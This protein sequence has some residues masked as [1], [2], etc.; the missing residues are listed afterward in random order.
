MN[1]T[2]RFPEH[3]DPRRRFGYSSGRVTNKGNYLKTNKLE[4]ARQVLPITL[5]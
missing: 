3:R 1:T 2:S 4:K 5:C